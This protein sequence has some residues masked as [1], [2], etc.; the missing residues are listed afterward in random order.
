MRFLSPKEFSPGILGFTEG[1][2]ASVTETTLLH[3]FGHALAKLADEYDHERASDAGKSNIDEAGPPPKWTP[4]IEQGF[5]GP[6]VPRKEKVIPS[7]N[8]HMNNQPTDNRWCPVCQLVLI[9]K[10]CELSGALAPW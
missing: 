2:K 10:I 7:D 1:K 9:A 3:E 4:L 8:C 5:L 6:P